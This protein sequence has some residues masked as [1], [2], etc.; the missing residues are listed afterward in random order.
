MLRFTQM[1]ECDSRFW[2]SLYVGSSKVTY[3]SV[4]KCGRLPR[5]KATRDLLCQI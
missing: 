2:R 3:R 1:S 4:Q 5:S